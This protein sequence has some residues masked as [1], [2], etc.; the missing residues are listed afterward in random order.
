MLLVIFYLQIPN[1]PVVDPLLGWDTF[2]K[3]DE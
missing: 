1:I 2:I 3:L